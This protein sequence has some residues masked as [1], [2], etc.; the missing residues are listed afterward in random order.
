MPLLVIVYT[1]NMLC[2]CPYFGCL[3]NVTFKPAEPSLYSAMQKN[4]QWMLL[5]GKRGI[6]AATDPERNS[7]QDSHQL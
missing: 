5:H 2:F 4:L 1:A 7:P 6:Q 3:A